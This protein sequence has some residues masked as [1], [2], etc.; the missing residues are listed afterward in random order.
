VRRERLPGGP[1]GGYLETVPDMVVE[2]ISPGDN[3]LA[4]ELKLQEYR[5]VG[6]PLVWVVYPELRSVHVIRGNAPVTVLRM[7]DTLDG[8]PAFPGFSCDVAEFFPE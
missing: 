1:A 3:A 7:G 2:V 6:I 4:F 5:D 8:E